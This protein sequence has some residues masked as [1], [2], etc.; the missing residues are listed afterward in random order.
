MT[1]RRK[2]SI[3][4]GATIVGLLLV[5][6]A[7]LWGIDALRQDYGVA[8]EGYQRL[9]QVYVAGAHL[10]TAQRLLVWSHPRAVEAARPE[11]LGGETGF[12]R[13]VPPVGPPMKAGQGWDA[14]KA[15]QVR[16]G[17]KVIGV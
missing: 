14:A 8:L 2:I 15:M 17:L 7:S 1:L 10:S 11:V 6:G 4:I 9:R 3:Q 5:S 12:D 16:V 13:L